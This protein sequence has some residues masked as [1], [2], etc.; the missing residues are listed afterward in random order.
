MKKSRPD[1]ENTQEIKIPKSKNDYGDGFN[2]YHEYKKNTK[3]KKNNFK[4][5]IQNNRNVLIILIPLILILLIVIISCCISFSTNNDST[6]Q[7]NLI[8]SDYIETS[9]IVYSS[10]QIK[11]TDFVVTPTE[12]ITVEENTTENVTT[13]NPNTSMPISTIEETTIVETNPTTILEEPTTEINENTTTIE[14]HI[15]VS[16]ILVA[17]VDN[18]LFVPKITGTFT[19]YSPE[20]ILEKVTVTTTTGTPQISHPNLN[21]EKSFTFNLNLDGCEGE[22]HIHLDSFDFYQDISSFPD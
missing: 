17:K 7:K 12:I 3:R 2:R 15:Q 20:E 11:N 21:N 18:S 10:K 4:Q 9:N 8:T 22:L 5:I 14:K 19:G 6:I 1:L 13:I 16:D